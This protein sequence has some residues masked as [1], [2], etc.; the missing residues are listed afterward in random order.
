MS[1][2][3]DKYIDELETD[4]KYQITLKD[5]SYLEAEKLSQE[6]EWLLNDYAAELSLEFRANNS[7]DRLNYREL[8]EGNLKKA[9]EGKK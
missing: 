4:L 7:K 2:Y 8:I 6:K 3:K 1:D 9:M 5:T